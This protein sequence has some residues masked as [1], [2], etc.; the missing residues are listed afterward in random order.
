LQIADEAIEVFHHLLQGFAQ[1]IGRGRELDAAIQV[2]LTDLFRQIDL[3]LQA[4]RHAVEGRGQ[5]AHFV[6]GSDR[7]AG[8]EHPEFDLLGHI[9]GVPDR[10]G[11]APRHAP[12]EQAGQENDARAYAHLEHGGEHGPGSHVVVQLMDLGQDHGLGHL[13]QHGPGLFSPAQGNGGEGVH[14]LGG[15]IHPGLGLA[16]LNILQQP[17]GVLLSHFRIE[18]LA[19]QA[20]IGAIRHHQTPFADDQ[21]LALAVIEGLVGFLA[22]FLHKI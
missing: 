19:D 4:V 17:G 10:P 20:R 14:G 1:L 18:R 21:Q 3:F 12:Q 13:N 2:A 16:R 7:E 15:L 5:G 6:I 8:V 22:D 11:K 9:G